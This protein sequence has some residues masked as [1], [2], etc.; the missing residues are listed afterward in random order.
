MVWTSVTLHWDVPDLRDDW[1]LWFPI[2]AL[3]CAAVGAWLL[4]VAVGRLIA[5]D[6]RHLQLPREVGERALQQGRLAGAG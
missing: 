1:L 5:F 4:R 3:T 2:I 6:H